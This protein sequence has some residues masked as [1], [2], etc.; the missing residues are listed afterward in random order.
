MTKTIKLRKL[1]IKATNFK[2]RMRKYRGEAFD[3]GYIETP[4]HVT[5]GSQNNGGS[6]RSSW[7]LR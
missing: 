6:W 2:I 3:G 1:V 5:I 7:P 4:L